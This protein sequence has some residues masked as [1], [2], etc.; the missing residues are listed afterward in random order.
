MKMQRNLIKEICKARG[1]FLYEPFEIVNCPQRDRKF[2]FRFTSSDLE[3]KGSGGWKII[4]FVDRLFY[5]IIKGNYQLHSLNPIYVNGKMK[6]SENY[7]KWGEKI[8]TE[9]PVKSNS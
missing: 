9:K 5:Q 1:L 6:M 8:E 2:I 4:P 7:K 3:R